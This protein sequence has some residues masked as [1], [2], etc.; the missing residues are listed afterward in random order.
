MVLFLT[1]ID[2]NNIDECLR[3]SEEDEGNVAN[4]S[5][6]DTQADCLF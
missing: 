5:L 1:K 2:D 4:F 3:N 6:H